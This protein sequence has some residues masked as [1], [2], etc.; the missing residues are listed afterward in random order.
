MACDEGSW[1]AQVPGTQHKE[2]SPGGPHDRVRQ[3][4]GLKKGNDVMPLILTCEL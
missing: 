3:D 4:T 2:C 1:G